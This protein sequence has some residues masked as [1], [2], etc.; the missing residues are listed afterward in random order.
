MIY[1]TV[2]KDEMTPHMHCSI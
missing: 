2:H 1:A